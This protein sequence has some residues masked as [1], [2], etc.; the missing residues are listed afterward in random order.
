MYS[1]ITLYR[2]VKDDIGKRRPLSKFICIKLAVFVPVLQELIVSS[3]CYD[4]TDQISHFQP[5]SYPSSRANTSL[6]VG[7]Q[8]FPPDIYFNLNRK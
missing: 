2:I 6:K 3:I 7:K 8:H 5:F 4:L 1:L